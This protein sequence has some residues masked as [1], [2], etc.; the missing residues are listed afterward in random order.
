MGQIEPFYYEINFK[1]VKEIFSFFTVFKPHFFLRSIWI[2]E[3]LKRNHETF[4]FLIFFELTSVTRWVCDEITQNS[5]QHI[6]C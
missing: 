4:L 2:S 6:L 1:V 3:L 5:T